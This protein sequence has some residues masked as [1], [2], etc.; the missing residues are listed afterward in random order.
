METKAAKRWITQLY[1]EIR[2]LAAHSLVDER[3]GHTLNPTAL[4]NEAY[5]R[6]SQHRD[7]FQ[8]DDEFRAAA[9][10]TMRRVL[11]DYARTRTRLKRGGNATPFSLLDTDCIASEAPI[12]HYLALGEAIQALEQHDERQ[13][14]VAD[15]RL[16]GKLTKRQIADRLGVSERTVDHDWRRVRAYLAAVLG[17]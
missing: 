10:V 15:L 14:N 16:F 11:V 1:D 6:L 17:E 13:A 5:L 12:E 2:A 3:V 9:A 7:G 8:D 4:V